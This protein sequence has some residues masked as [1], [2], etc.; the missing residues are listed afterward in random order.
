MREVVGDVSTHS[1]YARCVI[2][3]CAPLRAACRLGTETARARAPN[4]AHSVTRAR[5]T[6]TES[7]DARARPPNPGGSR[8]ASVSRLCAGVMRWGWQP[9]PDTTVPARRGR[10]LRRGRSGPDRPTGRR[11]PRRE[12]SRP[13]ASTSSSKVPWPAVAD[14]PSR[15]GGRCS[16]VR[17]TI[18]G[19]LRS[20][21]PRIRI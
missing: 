8:R 17:P 14:T 16:R 9:S 15:V 1:R 18:L 12:P 21:S 3:P 6:V 10:G 4:T 7:R 5:A 11:V 13:H 19:P 2:S 20:G